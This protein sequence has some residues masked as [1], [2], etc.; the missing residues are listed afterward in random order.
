MFCSNCGKTLKPDAT[1][2]PNC[3][4]VV[5]ESRFDGLPY[6]GAQMR[7][8]PGEAVRLP[9][10]HTRTTYMGSNNSE[11]A[12]VDARTTYRA[13]SNRV[14]S[15]GEPLYDSAEA[16]EYGEAPSYDAEPDEAE[17]F[18]ASS[19]NAPETEAASGD[20]PSDAA[21]ETKP[22]AGEAPSDT[23]AETEAAADEAP[24]EEAP[25]AER[26]SGAR[27]RRP[28]KAKKPPREEAPDDEEDDLSEL[29]ARD[30]QL[31]ART[32][33]SEDVRRYMSGL[34][35]D[36]NAKT[37]AP[38]EDA[39]AEKS[40]KKKS[41][42]AF[43]FLHRKKEEGSFDLDE[44]AFDTSDIPEDDELSETSFEADYDETDSEDAVDFT[45]G[46]DMTDEEEEAFLDHEQRERRKKVMGYL[47]YAVAALLIVG[48]IVGAIIGVSYIRGSSKTAPIPGVTLSLY[49][50][51]IALIKTRVS[52]EYQQKMLALYNVNDMNS[53]VTFSA[54]ITEDLDGIK[55]L[56]PDDPDI[57]DQRFISALSAIQEDVNN[58]LTNDVLALSD[59]TSTAADKQQASVER[60]QLVRRKVELLQGMTSY[61]Q[62][63][64]VIKGE[65]VEVIEQTTPEPTV[66]QETPVPYTTLSKGSKGTEVTELQTRLTELGYMNSTIDGDFGGKTRTAVQLFQQTVGLEA[67]GIADVETQTRL[68][69]DDA[70]T[71]TKN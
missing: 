71:Y 47:K 40:R 16:P 45:D 3:G 56:L 27:R 62:L 19:P 58:C 37:R 20:A 69:A 33:I 18:D 4:A 42:S 41:G 7:T 39:P 68:Y 15:Y 12:D 60:W 67:T 22:E 66:P 54:A 24:S 2:C 13:T 34:R 57:H 26:S 61:N 49:D 65:R 30:I 14:P 43:G 8:K 50:E 17:A 9:G 23:D 55:N 32:G 6:T 70:P 35:D 11:N 59:T 25:K 1:N 44:D 36:Y 31:E 38:A 53:M 10:N 46:E 51:G 21:A 28:A 52:D 63:D 29:R 48:V 64:N 5:G